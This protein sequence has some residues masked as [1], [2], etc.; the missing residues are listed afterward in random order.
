M[1][2]LTRKKQGTGEPHFR[3]LRNVLAAMTAAAA[4]SVLGG[5]DLE[6]PKIRIVAEGGT[7]E[8]V[9]P[10]VRT[11]AEEM[12]EHQTVLSSDPDALDAP[13]VLAVSPRKLP[14][15]EALPLALKGALLA[16]N[17]S[18]PAAGFTSKEV[19]RIMKN[20]Y[21]NWPGTDIPVRNIYLVAG[22]LRAKGGALKGKTHFTELS[23]ARIAA[24][25][26]K[27]DVTAIALLP[28]SFAAEG[29]AEI[30]LLPVDGIAPEFEQIL[31]GRYPLVRTYYLSMAP[32]A[33]DAV[34]RLAE[35]L[36]DGRF[37][38]LLL[39]HGFIPIRKDRSK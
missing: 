17:K 30:K 5:G 38:E 25:L 14:K 37:R 2:R 16:V 10:L 33:P 15:T 32:D 24:E 4:V 22:S 36:R 29:D 13:P 8:L 27:K 34:R 39:K 19:L 20:Q 31:G 23:S 6:L 18:N 35:R 12:P 21:P 1:R 11:L 28:L 3:T 7:A 26:V 9:R